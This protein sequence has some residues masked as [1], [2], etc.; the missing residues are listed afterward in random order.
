MH[1]IS[2]TF[3]WH[4]SVEG[5]SKLLAQEEKHGLFETQRDSDAD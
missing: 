3:Q 5:C 2:L 4:L 1:T